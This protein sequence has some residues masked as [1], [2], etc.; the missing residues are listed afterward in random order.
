VINEVK[1]AWD[2]LSSALEDP[3]AEIRDVRSAAFA[4]CDALLLQRRH[5]KSEKLSCPVCAIDRTEGRIPSSVH[6]EVMRKTIN[7]LD[8]LIE[9]SCEMGEWE[10]PIWSDVFSFR[11]ELRK[12]LEEEMR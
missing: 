8:R 4:L 10:S 6:I 11:K 12:D 3:E 2:D 9:W 5:N 7:L 1:I